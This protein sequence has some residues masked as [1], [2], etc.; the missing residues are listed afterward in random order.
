MVTKRGNFLMLYEGDFVTCGEEFLQNM[1]YLE[2]K[3]NNAHM[4]ILSRLK[5]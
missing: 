4:E 1:V 2:L 5:S 3:K